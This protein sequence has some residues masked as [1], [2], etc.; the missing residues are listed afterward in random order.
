MPSQSHN[1][2]APTQ[3]QGWSDSDR[4]EHSSG[5]IS[6][7]YSTASAG[8]CQSE[9]AESN[10]GRHRR[11]REKRQR[12]EA[13]RRQHYNM[14]DALQRS[15]V[16][17]LS[18]L[19]LVSPFSCSS[20][21]ISIDC[22]VVSP[23]AQLVLLSESNTA[24]HWIILDMCT[25]AKSYCL[26]NQMQRRLQTMP[27][28]GDAA[29]AFPMEG[30]QPCQKSPNSFEAPTYDGSIASLKQRSSSLGACKLIRRRE[31]LSL[32]TKLAL[33]LLCMSHICSQELGWQAWLIAYDAPDVAALLYHYMICCKCIRGAKQL[34]A[35]HKAI[36]YMTSAWH[37]HSL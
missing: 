24:C 27:G 9:E 14:R 34:Q 29:M 28:T 20:D 4:G 8:G 19:L 12:F 31:L 10:P 32:L 18:S 35:V 37:T 2:E 26:R 25:G 17:H 21:L 30:L 6:N 1:E 22:D 5:A 7:G 16:F 23:S 36:V 33:S 15:A 11:H 3:S 13:H